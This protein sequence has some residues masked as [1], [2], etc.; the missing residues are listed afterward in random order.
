MPVFTVLVVCLIISI[1]GVS[2]SEYS[3]SWGRDEYQ[4]VTNRGTVVQLSPIGISSRAVHIWACR[5]IYYGKISSARWVQLQ[6][7][8]CHENHNSSTITI[9]NNDY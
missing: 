4:E 1:I 5:G 6:C 3:R 7:L 9:T 2:L 8:N